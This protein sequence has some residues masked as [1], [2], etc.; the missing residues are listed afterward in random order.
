M[1][2]QLHN[3]QGEASCLRHLAIAYLTMGHLRTAL[4]NLWQ[5]LALYQRIGVLTCQRVSNI[6]WECLPWIVGRRQ[7]VK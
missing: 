5:S 1:R 2:R 4:R 7:W 3:Q 6:F